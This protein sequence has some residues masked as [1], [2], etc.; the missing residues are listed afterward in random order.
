MN[1]NR[2]L[3]VSQKKF[4]LIVD[5]EKIQLK[6]LTLK[7]NLSLFSTNLARKIIEKCNSIIFKV[8]CKIH[9]KTNSL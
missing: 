1:L 7:I 2:S 5:P 8:N 9:N 3:I 4:K 6:G